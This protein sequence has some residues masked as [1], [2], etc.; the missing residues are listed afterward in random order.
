MADLLFLTRGGSSP[1]NKPRV[2]FTAHDEDRAAFFDV[3][4]QEIFKTQNCVVYYHEPGDEA[5]DE[6]RAQDLGRM[7]LFVIPVTTKLLTRESG[8]QAEVDFAL[9]RHIPILPIMMEEGLEAVYPRLFGDLQ[10]LDRTLRDST[11]RP[12]P[13]KLADYLS[14]VLVGDEVAQ[15]VR[16]AFDAYIF[17]S[18]RKKDRKYA[19]QIMR[20][21]HKSEFCRNMAIWYD[22]YLVPGK[23]FP[24][25][26]REA[27]DKSDLFTLMVTPSLLEEGNYVMTTE[28]PMAHGVK[29]IFPV[30]AQPTDREAMCAKYDG[31]PEWAD[32]GD[33]DGFL[34]ALDG[35]VRTLAL[36]RRPDSPE[37]DFLMGLAYL[38]GIDVEVDHK[39]AVALI[40]SAAEAELPEA[41][42]K[43]ISM[44]EHGEGVQR[45][46]RATLPWYEK[47]AAIREREW[48]AQPEEGSE[49]YV[50]AL[51]SWGDAVRNV[52]DPDGALAVFRRHLAV[53]RQL[54]EE[55]G[56]VE[57][58]QYL[59][60][61][62]NRLGNVCQAEG[63]PSEARAYYEKAQATMEQLA[64]E[65]DAVE[66]RQNL[67]RSYCCLGDI[68][69]AEGQ[70]SEARAFF[71][72]FH[73]I[74]E[75][76]AE[77]TGT[78]QARR[79][80]NTAYGCLG[81][82]CLDE[83]RLPEARAYYEKALTLSEQLAEETGT[84]KDRRELCVAY[85]Y[86]AGQYYKE[87][88]LREARA[89]YEKALAVAQQLAEETGTVQD[90]QA[91]S[92]TYGS[93][94]SVCWDE[95][96]VTK[97]L[98]FF[99]KGQAIVEELD[100]QLGT[101]ETRSDKFWIKMILLLISI[102]R[103]FIAVNRFVRKIFGST[104]KPPE[105]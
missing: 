70:P 67:S 92:F 98:A 36:E 61:S 48:Q 20:L 28:Y 51:C 65:T 84:V 52:G 101:K 39:R 43:L 72:K 33:E 54:A 24:E 57:A 3:L 80:L 25:S 94:G 8:V 82:E 2:Y 31:L 56:T 75:Q 50:C 105:G 41:I 12:Y 91:L 99:K 85:N 78:V 95:R 44:Y 97:S 21:I 23:E 13:E 49:A 93:L 9:D 17:F 100:V 4:T 46:Y 102:T 14:A 35:R 18:Y 58:R 68:C 53:C 69:L 96:N 73:A 86:M 87:K 79:D 62:Y 90:R 104:K 89:Y 26:I 5:I 55:T 60:V 42:V 27:F 76:L 88:Q 1:R 32:A 66:D 83:G 63:R 34:R 77:E 30:A 64:E 10:F 37:H 11:T 71:E 74:S 19:D 59:G 81:N 15:R 47:M 7:N 29:P 22:E 40:T 16:D 103:P 45:D 38:T 6:E